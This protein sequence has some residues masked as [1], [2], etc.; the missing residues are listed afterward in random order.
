MIDTKNKIILSAIYHYEKSGV[1][2]KIE[3]IAKS[4]SISKKSI[5]EYF[6]S[7]QSI[8]THVIDY[9]F[10]DIKNQQQLILESTD[11]SLIKLRNLLTV[12]PKVMKIA[13]VSLKKL[14]DFYPAEHD[15]ILDRLNSNW[16][17]TFN[18]LDNAIVDGYITAIDHSHFRTLMVSLFDSI[19]IQTCDQHD[20]LSTYINIIFNGLLV[21]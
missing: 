7:K 11:N 13:G 21:R 15:H 10:D 19:L 2:F 3:D 17:P 4:L 6:D 20:L 14:Q 16:D 9:I 18:T 5:Y 8:I 12:Y 1:K